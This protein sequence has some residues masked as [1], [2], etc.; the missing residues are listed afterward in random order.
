MYTNRLRPFFVQRTPRP[1]T[2]TTGTALRVTHRRSDTMRLTICGRQGFGGF[3][4]FGGWYG[5]PNP[6]GGYYIYRGYYGYGG[7]RRWSRR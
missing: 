7:H 1:R 4:Q 3:R 2:T 5:Q 6:Y